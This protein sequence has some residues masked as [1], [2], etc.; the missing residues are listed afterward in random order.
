[1]QSVAALT[2]MLRAVHN[3][4]LTRFKVFSSLPRAAQGSSNVRPDK[5]SSKFGQ[6]KHEELTAVRVEFSVVPNVCIPC[7]ITLI[8]VEAPSSMCRENQP[9]VGG[10][11]MAGAVGVIGLGNL[12]PQFFKKLSKKP[13]W[14]LQDRVETV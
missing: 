14:Q 13:S 5:P 12:Q 11:R 3:G 7:G 10:N 2:K 9:S 8:Y 4:R 1:M 6:Q